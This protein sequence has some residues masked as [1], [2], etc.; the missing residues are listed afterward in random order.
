[1]CIENMFPN[2][3]PITGWIE[4]FLIWFSESRKI[5]FVKKI[6]HLIYKYNLLVEFVYLNAL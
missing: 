4:L 1:M 2:D 6:L 3:V 5:I